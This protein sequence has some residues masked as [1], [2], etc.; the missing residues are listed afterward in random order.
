LNDI[1]PGI[2]LTIAVLGYAAPRFVLPTTKKRTLS[3]GQKIKLW[4]MAKRM[5]KENAK[6]PKRAEKVEAKAEAKAEAEK[7][8]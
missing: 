5:N 8:E 3:F 6:P 2:A 1:P 7:G 4:W